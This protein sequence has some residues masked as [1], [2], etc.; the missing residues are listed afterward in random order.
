MNHFAEMFA[1][2]RKAAAALVVALVGWAVVVVTSDP[3]AITAA[4]W[5][6]GATALATGLG[7]WAVPNSD[8]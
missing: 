4:E 1:P 3:A 8:G 5:V 2:Y 6:G 7:V